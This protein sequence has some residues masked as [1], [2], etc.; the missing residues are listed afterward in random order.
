MILYEHPFNERIRTWLRLERLFAQF[1]YTLQHENAIDHHFALATLFEFIDVADRPD[2]R[3]EIMRDLE[4]QKQQLNTL[5]SNPTIAAD[6][7][8]DTL[9]QAQTCFERLGQ[10]Q[11]KVGSTLF[12]NEWLTAIRSR[13]NIPGCTCEFD[14]PAYH[15]WKHQAP[16]QRLA[17]LHAWKKHI[18]PVGDGI[19]LLLLLLRSSG[20]TQKNTALN[21]TFQQNLP[22]NKSF[23]LLR[24][25]MDAADCTIPEI[26]ANRL[27]VTIRMM[28]QDA[29]GHLSTKQQ[30]TNFQLTLC[31]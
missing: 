16:Q 21:G 2:L 7:L 12:K 31:A 6:V 20:Q 14:L 28:Q 22:Q 17:D 18:A 11:G 25:Q 9:I 29:N 26:S 19:R 13:I 8:E 24:L 10:M 23:Q 15:A 27:I 3:T 30:D 5:R 1:E 4:K